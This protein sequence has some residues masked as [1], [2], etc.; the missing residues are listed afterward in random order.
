M[1]EIDLGTVNWARA[2]FTLT[3]MYHW[4]HKILDDPFWY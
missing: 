1:G 3:A 2:Q 4:L